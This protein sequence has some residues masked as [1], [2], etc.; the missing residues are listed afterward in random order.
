L[1]KRTIKRALATPAGWWASRPLRTRGAIVLSYHR[2]C[3]P[4]EPFP[5]FDIETFREQMRWLSR[6]CRPIAP[7]ELKES[8][9]WSDRRRPPVL[10]T[11]DDGYRDYHDH[12]HPVLA[13]LG[14]PAVVFL[15]TAF[16]DDPTRLFWWDK[17][18]LA[19]HRTSRREVTLPWDGQPFALKDAAGRRVLMRAVKN[20]LRRIAEPRR[21]DLLAALLRELGNPDLE[22]PRQM[23]SWDEIRA[24]RGLTTWGGHTHTHPILSL[25]S[26][27]ALDEEIRLCRERIEAETGARPRY[28]AYP[29]GQAED[30]SDATQAALAR[31]GFEVA[32]ATEEGVNDPETDWMAV[33]RIP[34]GGSVPELA[35]VVSGISAA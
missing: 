17:V 24:L 33:K 13:E 12:I 23:L 30:F 7:D 26:E 27:A 9:G 19:F 34:G 35:W 8:T 18:H 2:V 29:N 14:I 31:Y 4:V 10:L 6:R 16:M 32:F 3:P 1:L 21:G 25:L 20:H 11:F 5:S 15:T 22:V 28:F